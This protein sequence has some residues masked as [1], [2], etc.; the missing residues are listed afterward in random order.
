M[1]IFTKMNEV[2][3]R[4]GFPQKTKPPSGATVGGTPPQIMAPFFAKNRRKCIK[5]ASTQVLGEL[6]W[7]A[8]G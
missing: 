6:T 4:L 5:Y 2:K 1:S 7:D 8:S 3:G